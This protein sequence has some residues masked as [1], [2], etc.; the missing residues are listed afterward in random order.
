MIETLK[1]GEPYVP[2]GIA[3]VALLIVIVIALAVSKGRSMRVKVGGVEVGGDQHEIATTLATEAIASVV[4]GMQIRL[5]QYG[6]VATALS[7]ILEASDAELDK[8]A[9]V[10]FS[11]LATRLAHLLREQGDHHHRVAI[12]LDDPNNPRSFVGIGRGLFDDGDTDMDT[13]D[14]DYTIAGLAFRAVTGDYYCRDT[15]TDP[16][17][18]PRKSTP[19]SFQSVYGIALG[20]P[21]DLWGVMTVDSRQTHGFPDDR[22]L[23]IRRFA[24]LASLGAVAWLSRI[25]AAPP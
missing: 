13:L 16:K 23:L 18:K 9:R 25:P 10:W 19:P 1:A 17:F 8:A 7:G 11:T 3:V 24:E 2:L 6:E 15:A 20:T 14:R 21:N 4:E 12:W 22:R 5:D